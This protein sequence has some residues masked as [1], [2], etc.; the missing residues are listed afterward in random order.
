MEKLK[1]ELE[2][3]KNNKTMAKAVYT[4]LIENYDQ[5]SDHVQEKTLSGCIDYLFKKAKS[6]AKNNCAVVEDSKVYK[7]AVEYYTTEPKEESK[8]RVEEPEEKREEKPKEKSEENQ[9]SLFEMMG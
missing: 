8:E 9:I 7:W 3:I 6:Q 1:Q 5:I 2:N 4:H